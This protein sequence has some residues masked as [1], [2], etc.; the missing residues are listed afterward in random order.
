M[1][2]SPLL[3][4]YFD[5]GGN[6]FDSSN[7]YQNEDSEKW[8]G[9]WMEARGVRERCVVTTKFPADYRMHKLGKGK[10]LSEIFDHSKLRCPRMRKVSSWRN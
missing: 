10:Y 8:L 3:D 6:F 4:A 1:D 9:E 2:P 5:A 7:G